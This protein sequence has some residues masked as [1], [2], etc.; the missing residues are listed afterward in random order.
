V[1]V[2]NPCFDI[3]DTECLFYTDDLDTGDRYGHCRIYQRS[4][5]KMNTLDKHGVKITQAQYD[6]WV[7]N[8]WNYPLLID[9]MPREYGGYEAELP[10]I[11]A[12]TIEY[13]P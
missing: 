9:H 6:W 4:G 13:V 1:V 12:Y 5:N 11:C 8:C 3:G 10:P 7:A 2:D